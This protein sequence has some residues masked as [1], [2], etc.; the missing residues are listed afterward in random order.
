M[1]SRRRLI[2]VGG[3][4]VAEGLL[5]PRAA[6]AEPSAAP[7][8]VQSDLTRIEAATGGRLGVALVDTGSDRV[9]AHRGDERFPMCSTAKVLACATV[10]SRVDAGKESLDRRVRYTSADLVTY[11]PRTKEHVGGEG[12]TL[13]AI[14]EAALTL[15]DNTAMNLMLGSLGGPAAVTGFA[16]ALGDPVT[17]LDRMEPALNEALPGDPRDTTTPTAMASDIRKIALGDALSTSSRDRLCAWMVA[18]TTGDAKIRAGVPG[19]WRI[20]DKTGSGERGTSNDVAVIWPPNRAPI[21]VVVYLTGATSI[22]EDAR[23]AVSA[24]VGRVAAAWIGA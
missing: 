2:A 6:L 14:C 20:G 8:G 13:A 10:L 19:T 12:M 1:L 15:S 23:S 11:S 16:R 9:V 3:S 5:L 21:I 18:C 7:N 24:A 17:R 4:A 22:S